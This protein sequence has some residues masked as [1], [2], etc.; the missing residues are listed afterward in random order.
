M[1]ATPTDGAKTLLYPVSDLG[2]AKGIFSAL[3]GTAPQVDSPYYVG[4][5]AAGQ[6]IGLVPRGGPQAPAA[7]VAYWHVADI[8]AK[9]AELTA[10]GASIQDQLREVGGGRRVAT[11]ADPDGNPIGLLQDG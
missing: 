2:K 6:H 5:D 7:A 4:F 8:A 10:A 11:V 1:T 9:L 3:L